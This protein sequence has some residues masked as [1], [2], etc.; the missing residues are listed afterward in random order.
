[1]SEPGEGWAK[2]ILLPTMA[3]ALFRT[4]Q[5]SERRDGDPRSQVSAARYRWAYALSLRNQ[6]KDPVHG[7]EAVAVITSRSPET[8][9]GVMRTQ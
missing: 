1:M 7:A 4:N 9:A 6:S 5:S 3:A 2:T 8:F